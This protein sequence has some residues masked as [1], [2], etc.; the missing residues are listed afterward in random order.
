MSGLRSIL[1]PTMQMCVQIC[2][3]QNG[4]TSNLINLSL[5]K[6]TEKQILP[7]VTG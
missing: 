5:L 7:R 4:A 3:C 2:V 6:I 1:K